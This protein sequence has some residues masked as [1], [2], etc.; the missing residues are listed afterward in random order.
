LDILDEN[1]GGLHE[2]IKQYDNGL[3]EDTDTVKK[4]N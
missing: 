4:V 2:D 1:I 3:L